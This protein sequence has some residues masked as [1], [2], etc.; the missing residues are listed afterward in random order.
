MTVYL[1][2]LLSPGRPPGIRPRPRSRYEPESA[3]PFTLRS[4]DL[5]TIDYADDSA[6]GIGAAEPD[7]DVVVD[8]GETARS[9]TTVR[10]HSEPVEVD[11]PR[12]PALARSAT[13]PAVSAADNTAD[14][15]EPQSITAPTTPAHELDASRPAVTPQAGIRSH[16]H[17][18]VSA[19][20]EPERHD[21]PEVIT[22]PARPLSSRPESRP[23]PPPRGR[24][25]E[26]TADPVSEIQPSQT[27]RTGDDGT[28]TGNPGPVAAP[29]MS[30]HL[31]RF[32]DAAVREA[33][34]GAIAGPDRAEANEVNVY[35]ER[36]DVQAAKASSEPT[37]SP[38]R[39]A[40]APTSLD[41]YLRSR[42]RSAR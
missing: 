6:E 12:P 15:G 13:S 16:G 22:P 26:S 10:A 4:E 29:R 27:T 3:T 33:I 1:S 11:A 9:M 23:L 5:A 7:S 21:R 36:V 31:P 34:A 32:V 41:S 39:P 37:S 38:R 20:W 25:Q 24:P 14:L 19:A 28:D 8:A 18:S 2:R 17:E 42:S 35:I 30:Q 40:A